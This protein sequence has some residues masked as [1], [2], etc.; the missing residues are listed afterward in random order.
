M[1]ELLG[2]PFPCPSGV[3]HAAKERVDR[4]SRH[5]SNPVQAALAV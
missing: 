1:N 4:D 2:R 5:W 3:P